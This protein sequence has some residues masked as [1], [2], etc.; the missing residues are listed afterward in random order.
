MSE[1]ALAGRTEPLIYRGHVKMDWWCL[2]PPTHCLTECRFASRSCLRKLKV[3][4]WTRKARRSAV[5]ERISI[6]S[7]KRNKFRS[8]KGQAWPRAVYIARTNSRDQYAA[9]ATRFTAGFSGAFVMSAWVLA[10]V[11]SSSSAGFRPDARVFAHVRRAAIL[12]GKGRAEQYW[13]CPA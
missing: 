1:P 6:R 11:A 13:T 12:R 8:T 4:G 5:V 3:H 2:Q 10:E 9:A 7:V